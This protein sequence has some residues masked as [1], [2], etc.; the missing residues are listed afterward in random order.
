MKQRGL[1][2]NTV[3]LYGSDH[4]LLMGEYGMGG[5]ALLYDLASKIPCLIHDPQF[6]SQ[7]RGRKLDQLVSSL[8]YT[9]RFSTT[10]KWSRSNSWTAEAC[11]RW[12]KAGVAWRDELFLESLYTGRDN[13]FQEGIRTW[14]MEVYS[15]VRRRDG[16]RGIGR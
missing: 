11:D 12:S 15:H 1:D 8:D 9:R 3:I 7:L 5:K 2:E 4:G 6:P 13:P 10:P 16:L 14:E